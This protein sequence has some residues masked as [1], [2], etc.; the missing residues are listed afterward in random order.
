MAANRS[1]HTNTRAINMMNGNMPREMANKMTP[2][3]IQQMEQAQTLQQQQQPKQIQREQGHMLPAN[4][5]HLK[6]E[7]RAR[8]E[9]SARSRRLRTCAQCRSQKRRC[10]RNDMLQACIDCAIDGYECKMDDFPTWIRESRNLDESRKRSATPLAFAEQQRNYPVALQAHARQMQNQVQA[11]MNGV[12]N[13]PGQQP[14][15]LSA[16]ER[17]IVRSECRGDHRLAFNYT[18]SKDRTDNSIEMKR[19][20]LAVLGRGCGGLT[21]HSKHVSS[22]MSKGAFTAPKALA[23]KSN[24]LEI[25]T[26]TNSKAMLRPAVPMRQGAVRSKFHREHVLAVKKSSAW[27]PPN[28]YTASNLYYQDL[29]AAEFLAESPDDY[30]MPMISLTPPREMERDDSN[31]NQIHA[32]QPNSRLYSRQFESRQNNSGDFN[33]YPEPDNLM[34]TYH[35]SVGSDVDLQVALYYDMKLKTKR[36]MYSGSASDRCDLTTHTDS[37]VTRL[38]QLAR[39]CQ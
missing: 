33:D 14:S 35:G 39:L 8:F 7:A 29:S 31:M 27:P 19:R 38:R 11:D 28:R 6:T 10:Q 16:A 30:R 22:R 34:P 12:V 17:Q 36:A 23:Q 21:L 5:P 18:L 25:K 26:T 3:Q 20:R 15:P 2:R 1:V 13:T 24:D 4:M 37:H 9:S 32:S